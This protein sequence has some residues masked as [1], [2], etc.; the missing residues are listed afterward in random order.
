MVN[1]D[2]VLKRLIIAD[3]G[4]SS[5]SFALGWFG[6]PFLAEPWRGYEQAQR[7]AALSL[8][9]WLL[10]PFDVFLLGLAPFAWLALWRG[11][12]LG[13]LLYTVLVT[14]STAL[15][16]FE[17]PIATS[18]PGLLLVSA[19]TMVIGAILG[20]LYFSDLRFRY[21]PKVT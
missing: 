12:R 14:V 20:L 19:G 18:G 16:A 21:A 8:H 6:D 1:D 2:P 15:L 4:F 10:L 5:I 13:R 11:H 17:Q 7:E 3:I 9:D